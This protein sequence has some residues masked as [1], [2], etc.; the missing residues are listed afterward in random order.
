MVSHV[1]SRKSK[2]EENIAIL[3]DTMKS[4]FMV[5]QNTAIYWQI[6][7]MQYPHVT[8]MPPNI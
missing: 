5:V 4:T 8:S 1:E 2:R 3:M 6:N 7:L